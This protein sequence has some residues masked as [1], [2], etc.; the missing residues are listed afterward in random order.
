VLRIDDAI[1]AVE[2]MMRGDGIDL[3]LGT[4]LAIVRTTSG[5]IRRYPTFALDVRGGRVR[6]VIHYLTPPVDS[7][8]REVL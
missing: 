5:E 2:H 1:E 4:P 3:P 8:R 7:E 6:S